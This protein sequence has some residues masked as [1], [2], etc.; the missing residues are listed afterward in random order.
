MAKKKNYV[1]LNSTQKEEIRRLTQLANRRIKA[2]TKAYHAAGKDVVPKE[3]V[4]P[5]QVIEQWHAR[6]TPMS[7]SVKFESHKAYRE[8]LKFLRSFDKKA[9][10]ESRPGIREYT[11]VQREKTLLAL[12][13]SLGIE[14]PAKIQ[15]QVKKL[16]A[17]Q[18][19][20]FWNKFSNISAKMVQ[21][22][23]SDAAIIET[24]SEF[25]PEDIA[26]I[27]KAMSEGG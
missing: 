5:Y 23:A 24:L 12:E 6:N 10:G 22:Y 27:D 13:T 21:K 18:L 14:P 17:V 26:A 25:F 2:A 9:P 1:D 16:N 3:M 19:A 15:Q 11:K 7:R 20:E 8:H 4:G